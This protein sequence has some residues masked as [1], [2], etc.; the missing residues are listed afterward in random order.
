MSLPDG[1]AAI[2]LD[3]SKTGPG[4]DERPSLGGGR[5]RDNGPSVT[6]AS[7]AASNRVWLVHAF[8]WEEWAQEWLRELR[9]AGV[10]RAR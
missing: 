4:E 5:Y 3:L 2:R 9:D 8:S 7:S 1:S 10:L 6:G